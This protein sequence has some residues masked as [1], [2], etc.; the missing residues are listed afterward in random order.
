MLWTSWLWKCAAGGCWYYCLANMSSTALRS[1]SQWLLCYSLLLTT[2]VQRWWWNPWYRSIP[3]HLESS[4]RQ[5]KHWEGGSSKF[6]GHWQDRSHWF[7]TL[8]CDSDCAVADQVTL[9]N[10]R[11]GIQCQRPGLLTRV[12]CCCMIMVGS[13]VFKPPLSCWTPDIGNVF[14]THH[15]APILVPRT[16]A[17]AKLGKK[18]PR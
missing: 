2:K 10:L 4:S 12:Y 5:L 16:F 6:L 17:Y 11:E 14:P 3:L 15:T 8:W 18:S 7:H 1:W 9:Q 13:V